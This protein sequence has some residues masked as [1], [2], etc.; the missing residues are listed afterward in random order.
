MRLMRNTRLT[1][2]TTSCDVG[3]DGLSTT[4]TPSMSGPRAEAVVDCLHQL[5]DDSFADVHLTPRH[6]ESGGVFV[7]AT[8]VLIRHAA[9]IHVVLR[10]HA[11]P[12]VPVRDML[13]EHDRL[14]LPRR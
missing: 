13:E 9:D 1:R 11:D 3:P 8:P 14:D 12:Q 10:A 6:G 5:G 7:A 4:S 2:A